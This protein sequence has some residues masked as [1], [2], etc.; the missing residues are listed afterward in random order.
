MQE[1]SEPALRGVVVPLV[2]FASPRLQ[3]RVAVIL[4]TISLTYP[5]LRTMDLVPTATMIDLAEL[6]NADRAASL[7]FRFD[8]EEVLLER[9]LEQIWFGWGRWGRGFIYDDTGRGSSVTDGRWIITLG[10]YG[11]FG[12]IAE[13]GLLA[14]SVFRAASALRFAGTD[15]DRRC[16]AALALIVA[17]N[18]V[19]LLPNGFLSPLTWLLAGALLGR[20][21]AALRL[22][23]RL[24]PAIYGRLDEL[25]PELT[26]S[27]VTQE[28]AH[29]TRM[30]S[31]TG[32][33]ARARRQPLKQ[34]V[35]AASTWTLVGYGLSQAIRFG[36]SLVMTRLLVPDMF[37][38]MAIAGIVMTGLA[39]FS[40]LGLK[41]NIIQSRRGSDPVYLNTA[42]VVQI[43]RGVV[44]W[45]AAFAISLLVLL[46]NYLGMVPRDS[47]Y[48][49]PSLPS[50]I[51]ITSLSAIIAG[52]SSTKLFEASRHLELGR[53]TLIEI[54]A[55]IT[56][57]LFM[58]G[59]VLIDRSI[60][61]LVA[62]GLTAAVTSTALSHSNWLS[63]VT[64]RWQ[65]DTSAF[66]EIIHFGKWIFLSSILGFLMF[67]SDRPLL[68]ALISSST[69]GVYVI[70]FT[71]FTS[72]ETIFDRIINNVSYSA[73]SEVA[74]ERP[75][76]LKENYYRFYVVIAP[77]AYFC[78]GVLM[79]VGQPL[80]ELLYDYRYKEA[81]WM[82]E[83][84]AAGSPYYSLSSCL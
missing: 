76:Q 34:R 42:W 60:W 64:N 79:C 4:A 43:V 37:G 25:R 70:A 6:N 59:W 17:I 75:S 9:A 78:A 44:L 50:V 22:A 54:T 71:I 12:F 74:R 5:M 46:I 77:I 81:G 2:L 24:T 30:P 11:L 80:I 21:E 31:N 68:G 40:D 16:L 41:Q 33:I 35:V 1:L 56:G 28:A 72:L 51:A 13:F 36:S 47:V 61:A 55:Q 23:P 26:G 53:V 57:L 27:R 62:G 39:M 8:N 3:L 67:N 45:M 69:L 84:L 82:L 10:T 52:L 15:R 29:P 20:A 49:N 73:L 38:V 66:R 63:G 18:M 7:K 48:A 83:I 19:D 58:F 14:L 32:S 65:W